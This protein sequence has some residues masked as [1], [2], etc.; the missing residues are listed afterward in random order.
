MSN[1][2]IILYST[3]DNTAQFRLKAIDGMVWLTVGYRILSP[4]GT[5][6]RQW[7]TIIFNR[8]AVA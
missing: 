2:E 1:G 3:G 6:F 8:K 4:R 7:A 5:Q